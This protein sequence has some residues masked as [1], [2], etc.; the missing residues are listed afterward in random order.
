MKTFIKRGVTVFALFAAAVTLSACGDPVSIQNAYVGKVKTPEGM[1]EGIIP[2]SSFRLD[3]C[4]R[5]PCDRIIALENG[6]YEFKEDLT[7]TSPQ[8]QL[9][10]SVDIRGRMRLR[11]EEAQNYVF[12][13]VPSVGT[14]TARQSVI[15]LDR[16]YS[17]YAQN[18][19][20]TTARAK[21]SERSIQV[22][23]ENREALGTE[24]FQVVNEALKE[25]PF[26]LTQIGIAKMDPPKVI[27]DAQEKAKEREVAIK[28]AEAQK[29]IDLAKATARAE[30]ARKNQEAEL[31]EAETQVLVN[32]KLAE[33][34]SEAW[35]A[36]RAVKVLEALAASDN[37]VIV[38]PTEALTNPAMMVGVTNNAL[39]DGSALSTK[40]IAGTS[41]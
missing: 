28:G 23:L 40:P 34:V 9:L 35:L 16:V 32:Q 30:V 6:D 18:I 29:Q 5:E 25:T 10:F 24:M 26:E 19:L 41:Q 38:M 14:E 17:K 31:I 12:Q 11:D 27:L 4:W 36:Q 3:T 1:R 15:T 8:E 21:L 33:G 37:K 2:P 20:R 39:K 22:N 7:F 13:W